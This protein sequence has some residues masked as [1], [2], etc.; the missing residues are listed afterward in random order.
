MMTR[1]KTISPEQA[2]PEPAQPEQAATVRP[3]STPEEAPAAPIELEARPQDPALE[4]ADETE[5]TQAEV[6]DSE[7]AHLLTTPAGLRGAIEALLFVSPEPLSVPRLCRT[8]EV[9]D[10]KLV[11]AT[12]NQLRNEYDADR[13]G[14]QILETAGGF[15]MATREQFGDLILHLR[16][17]KR[18]PVLS[19]ASLETL[20]IIAYRQPIIRA[21][22]EAV[23]GVESSGTIRNLVDMGLVQ[24]VGRKEV[25]GRPP[26]Y[27]TNEAFLQSFGLRSLNDLPSISELKRRFVESAKETAPDEPADQPPAGEETKMETPDK[28]QISNLKSEISNRK[29]PAMP[30][31]ET[32]NPS[33]SPTA[34][35]ISGAEDE[36]EVNQSQISNLKSEISNRTA[37]LGGAPRISHEAQ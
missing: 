30:A 14:F 33:P 3:D 11:L 20:A 31:E 19:P 25:L 28:S 2:E 8:L 15:Q 5:E 18:R 12:L 35:E 22:V 9:H 29:P 17:R 21:E 13:R 26:M 7:L 10:S 6:V 4:S 27:G 23:R 37:A 16:N 36:E 34:E 24:M 32:P 1:E